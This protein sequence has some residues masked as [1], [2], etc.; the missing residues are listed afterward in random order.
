MG[1]IFINDE[2]EFL[3]LDSCFM[4]S[5]VQSNDFKILMYHKEFVDWLNYNN[6][7]VEVDHED[8]RKQK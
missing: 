2:F 3:D 1:L 7:V 6:G 5:G 8:I 4:L